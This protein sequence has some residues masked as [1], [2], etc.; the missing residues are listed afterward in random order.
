MDTPTPTPEEACEVLSRARDIIKDG[1]NW[2]T[3]AFTRCG[4]GGGIVGAC[5]LG[6]IAMAMPREHPVGHYAE[7]SPEVQAYAQFLS[8]PGSEKVAP[9]KAGILVPGFNDRSP[10]VDPVVGM[11]DKAIARLSKVIA[12]QQNAL[13]QGNVILA[14][15]AVTEPVAVEAPIVVRAK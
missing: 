1:E 4:E 9:G 3:G 8:P 2:T 6:A 7:S 12:Q 11:F 15:P 13:P 5:A 14:I 10:S